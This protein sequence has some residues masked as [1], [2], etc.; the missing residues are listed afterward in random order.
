MLVEETL[1][2][3]APCGRRTISEAAWPAGSVVVSIQRGASLLFPHGDTIVEPGDVVSVLTRPEHA[4]QLRTWL[5]GPSGE[6]AG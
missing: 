6:G 1:T 5:R 2:D 3:G 4:E